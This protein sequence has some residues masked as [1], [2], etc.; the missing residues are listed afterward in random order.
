MGELSISFIPHGIVDETKRQ[1]DRDLFLK[2]K[3]IRSLGH[4]LIGH[5]ARKLVLKDLDTPNQDLREAL[6]ESVANIKPTHPPLESL[7]CA[8]VEAIKHK[9]CP[10][11]GTKACSACKLVSYCS[12]ASDRYLL[13][14]SPLI[15]RDVG[16]SK[17]T[18]AST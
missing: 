15:L 14:S 1:H 4:E 12:Q 13:P 7:P 17:S 11:P 9:A 6:L 10:K 18:L 16:V 2:N 8:N 3:N 5:L